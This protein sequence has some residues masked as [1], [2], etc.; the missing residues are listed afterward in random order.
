MIGLPSGT[1]GLL[2]SGGSMAN[3]VGLAVAQA[4][5]ATG[6]GAVIGV[7][8][9]LALGRAVASLLFGIKPADPAAVLG[10]IAVLLAV[11]ALA[12]YLPARRAA[13]IDPM[14]ALR[15]E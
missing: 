2:V 11:A 8:L 4:L 6:I 13:G 15:Y 7:L 12:A 14:E 9:A 3:L 10:A 1:G 5:R